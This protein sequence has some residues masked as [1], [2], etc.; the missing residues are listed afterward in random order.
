M[1]KKLMTA[2]VFAGLLVAASVPA[3]EGPAKPQPQKEHQ[4]LDQLVGEWTAEGEAVMD[5]AA[6]PTK[7]KGTETGRRLGGFWATCEYTG[8]FMGE[9]FTGVFT[10]GYDPGRKSYVA[11]WIDNMQSH[12][13]QYEGT[14]DATGKTLTLEAEGPC[15][16]QPGKTVKVRDTLEILSKDHRV[17]TMR[18]EQDG[19]WVTAMTLHYR[20][21]A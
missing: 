11:T 2:T 21:K 12:L 13:W 16:H 6:A 5:P 15:C 18:V 10:L 17:L 4:W 7:F 20:R 19:K 3:Q 9:P 8:E 1:L 14:L